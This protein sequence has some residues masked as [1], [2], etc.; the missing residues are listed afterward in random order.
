MLNGSIKAWAEDDRPREKLL[1]RGAG[2]LTDAEVVALLI[3]SG[4]REKSAVEVGRE[5]LDRL[6]GLKGL[7]RCGV[8]EMTCVKGVGEAKSIT[9]VAAFELARRKQIAAFKDF[10][11]QA[12]GSQ[13]VASFAQPI[14]G[15][16]PREVFLALFLNRQNKLIKHKILF[17]GGVSASV[18]DVKV[19]FKEALNL[20]A[21]GLIICHNHPSG[22]LTPSA[23]DVELTAKARAGCRLLDISLLDHL[24]ITADGYYSFR[25]DGKL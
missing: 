10:D 12:R 21:S 8:A 9:L 22:S 14:I 16:L 17:E 25:D 4:S 6:G 2:A 11:F 18:V 19:L 13:D 20:L 7:A 23:E 5:L 15:D 3:G 24:I 1:A